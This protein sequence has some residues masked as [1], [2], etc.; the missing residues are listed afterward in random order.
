MK[1]KRIQRVLSVLLCAALLL[2]CVSAAFAAEEKTPAIVI[3]GM[4][5]RE[6][7]VHDTGKRAFP[8]ATGN[9][10]KGVCLGIGIR[11]C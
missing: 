6:M 7:T 4:G 1:T 3:S 2:C 10:I 9:I 11:S 8:P 5:S